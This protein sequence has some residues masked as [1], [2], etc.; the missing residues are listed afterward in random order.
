[1]TNADVISSV[2]VL[3]VFN[4]NDLMAVADFL[5]KRNFQS[6]LETACLE[7]VEE[8]IV[9]L[10]QGSVPEQVDEWLETL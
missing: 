8:Q 9:E 7:E 1:M 5:F 4:N 3:D 10:F 2:V 6:M